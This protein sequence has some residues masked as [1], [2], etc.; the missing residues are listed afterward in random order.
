MGCPGQADGTLTAKGTAEAA[1]FGKA[2]ATAEANLRADYLNQEVAWLKANKCP[3]G[4]TNM[5]YWTDPKPTI[6]MTPQSGVPQRLKSLGFELGYAVAL[7]ETIGIHRT[8]YETGNARD[9]A[10][11]AR[12]EAARKAEEAARKAAKEKK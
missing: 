10:K 3:D 12:E 4:C 11:A 5:D 1:D 6:A 2:M 7:T 9:T 8:C